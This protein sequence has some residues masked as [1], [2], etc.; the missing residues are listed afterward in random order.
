M[1]KD[2]REKIDGLTTPTIEVSPGPIIPDPTTWNVEA[3]VVNTTLPVG[4]ESTTQDITDIEQ[5][6]TFA[7]ES[8]FIDEPIKEARFKLPKIDKAKQTKDIKKR[9]KKAQEIKEGKTVEYNDRTKTLKTTKTPK[10]VFNINHVADEDTLAEWI[11]AGA[12]IDKLGEFKKIS[13]KDI[14]AKYNTPEV[15][16]MEAGEVV[17]KSTS[18]KGAD[19]WIK[20]E[21]K[22]AQQENRNIPTYSTA[23]QTQYSQK[24]I[25]EFLDPKNLAKRQTVA[26]PYEVFK[27]FHFLT[28][29]SKKAFDKAEEIVKILNDK[30][31]KNVT[32]EMRLEFQQA[33]VLEGILSKKLKGV[34]VDLARSLGV[35]SEARKA[36]SVSFARQSEEAIDAFGGPKTIDSF[37]KKYVKQKNA[38]DRHKMAEVLSYPW[39]KKVINIIPTTY[40]NDLIAGFPTS[41]RNVLG[42][43]SLNNFTK[44]ENFATV[45]V[46]LIRTKGAKALGLSYKEERMM[47]EEATAMMLADSY[48][49]KDAWSRFYTTLMTN[50]PKDAAVKFDV[51]GDRI[52]D[53]FKYN[54]PGGRAIEYLGMYTTFSGRLLQSQDEFMKGIAFGHKIIGLATRKKILERSRLIDEGVDPRI[55]DELSEEL[56]ENILK[57]PTQEMIEEGVEYARYATQTSPLTGNLR[58]LENMTNNPG[59]K[60]WTVFMRVTSNII[61]S[62]SERNAFTALLTPRVIKNL[63]AG[64]V[65]RDQAIAR[66]ATGSTFMLAMHTLTMDHKLTGAGPYNYRDREAMI[67]DGWQPYSIVFAK[68]KLSKEMIKKLQ[69]LTNVSISKDK[70]YVSYQGIEPISILMA[71]AATTAEYAQLGPKEGELMELMSYST[72]AAAEYVGEHPLL[73]GLGKIMDVIIQDKDGSYLYEVIQEGTLQYSDYVTKGIPSPVGVPV[74]IGTGKKVLVNPSL[75]GFWRNYEK[76]INPTRSATKQP[77]TMKTAELTGTSSEKI[78]EAANRGWLE[79]MRKACAANALCSNELPNEKDP[80]T[81]RDIKNGTGNLYDLWSPFKVTSNKKSPAHMV[82]SEFGA[83]NPTPDA[84]RQSY[85]VIDGVRLS[86]T[87]INELIFYAN[88]NGNLEKTVVSLGKSLLNKNI[89]KSEKAIII[90]DTISKFYAMAKAKLIANNPDLR[91]KIKE[92]SKAVLTEQDNAR[93]ANYLKGD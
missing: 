73:Q 58:A 43:V 91:L 39:W 7:Q 86:Q 6:T 83:N 55:A 8:S 80:L 33:V 21:I 27:Q 49:W 82:I 60:L 61:G 92:V 47:F 72:M 36:G 85:G 48:T 79:A 53:P 12:Q 10:Q 30:G 35:L 26:D 31:P 16:V 70:V 62:A 18:Q 46:G 52:N 19:N 66:V 40:I 2:I 42:F 65:K 14:A 81:G 51:I 84:V 88:Q 71:Q 3:D 90:N 29:V 24:W 38:E 54:I 9:Q 63:R 41:F 17:Y 76:M 28:T 59:L 64:G 68:G 75:G 15:V 56:F 34:Q 50:K 87:Q 78:A 45:G 23:E 93:S 1:A 44:V 77:M 89:P 13:Y 25:N 69:T 32:D 74:D 57:N 37:A 67:A 4:T 5:E 11:E 20:K 22:K